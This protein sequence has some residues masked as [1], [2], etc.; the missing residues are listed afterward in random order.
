VNANVKLNVSGMVFTQSTQRIENIDYGALALANAQRERNNIEQQKI[1]DDKERIILSEIILDPVKA[2]ENGT[3]EGYDLADKSFNQVRKSYQEGTG[4]KS[5][6]WAFVFPKYFFTPSKRTKWQNVS[7]EGMVTDVMLYEPRYNRENEKVNYEETFE[8][9]TWKAGTEEEQL[10]DNGILTKRFLH[11]KD[12]NRATVA[13]HSGYRT[14]FI[15]EDKFEYF[16]TDFYKV[17]IKDVGNG[18]ELSAKVRYHGDKDEITFEQLEGRRHYLK[19][20]IEK[21]IASQRVYNVKLF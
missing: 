10:D 6:A 18:Y 8:K 14:T 15:W 5:Y 1:I 7:G 2:Y 9:D 21:V 12:L 19:G 4:L 13:G 11:K 17:F 16:I 3:M 20:L